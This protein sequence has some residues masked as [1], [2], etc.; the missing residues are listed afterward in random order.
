MV[1]GNAVLA[2]S[3]KRGKRPARESAES[4]PSKRSRSGLVGSDSVADPY[5]DGVEETGG[6]EE[7]EGMYED[8]NTG[9]EEVEL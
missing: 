8:A 3:A 7:E 9:A 2:L 5:G 6:G 1:L 4:R